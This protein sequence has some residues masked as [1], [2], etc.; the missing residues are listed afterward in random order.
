MAGIGF[1]LYKILQEGTLG[2]I[3]KVLFLGTIIVAGP[4]ILSVL[5]IYV[6]Q[7][8]AYSAIS[9]APDLFTVSIVYVY[10][11]SLII[12]GGTHY[13]F[14]RYIADQIYIENDEAI[15]PALQTILYLITILSVIISGIFVLFNDFSYI[16]NSGLYKFSLI[17]LFI[18]INIIWVMLI[19]IALLKEYNKI[20]ISY[21]FGVAVS[22]GGVFYLGKDYGVAGAVLGYTLGQ[23]IIVVLLLLISQKSY[24]LKRIGIN[25]ELFTY[26]GKY[27]YLFFI[28][29]FFNLG[30]WSDKI[31]YWFVLGNNI[32]G[33]LF[34]YYINYDIPVFLAF[35]TMI[36]GLV[37]FLVVSEPVFHTEYTNFIRNILEDTLKDIRMKKD[38]MLK[39]LRDGVSRL[40]FFQG[41]WTIGLMMN[42]GQFLSFMG[43][44]F[45]DRSIISVLIVAVFFHIMSLTLQIYLL[46]LELRREALLS[47]VIYFV[48]NAVL[49]LLF[50][51]WEFPIP[52]VSYMIAAFLSSSY[53]GYHLISKS[54]IIDFIIFNKR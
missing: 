36:P 14:S 17:L 15:P 52:G 5:S 34:F 24:P 4:W 26:F 51:F 22:I 10:A 42:M 47:T 6:I 29:M 31:M 16:N 23:L 2:S 35:L 49:T 3:L 1:E 27:K 28:G 13:I 11:F 38:L 32:K 50:I 39:S 25:M 18:V 48:G 37:Y 45:I 21:L 40:I 54:P 19:Y 7:K 30:I 33:T 43:Y 9:E 46:Y 20:F 44:E 53:S 12:F 41:V 8:Y